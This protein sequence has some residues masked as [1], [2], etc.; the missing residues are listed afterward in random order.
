M[1]ILEDK[2]KDNSNSRNLLMSG[3]RSCWFIKPL[4]FLEIDTKT[5]NP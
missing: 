1:V 3:F 5:D 4:D 2:L